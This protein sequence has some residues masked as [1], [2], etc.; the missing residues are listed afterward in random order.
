MRSVRASQRRHFHHSGKKASTH[1][2]VGN[3]PPNFPRSPRW[4]CFAIF[5]PPFNSRY[6]FVALRK[7][8]ATLLKYSSGRF[9]VLTHS[10]SGGSRRRRSRVWLQ[11][12]C[13]LPPSVCRSILTSNVWNNEIN[14]KL[15]NIS[16]HSRSKVE[17]FFLTDLFP[18]TPIPYQPLPQMHCAQRPTQS[19]TR[20]L[21]A[22]EKHFPKVGVF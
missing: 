1:L 13:C 7:N 17:V 19:I 16:V 11:T 18:P 20:H 4:K 9:R 2:S 15:L 3:L 5:S 14:I 12:F 10:S 8:T 22:E 6:F 21:A